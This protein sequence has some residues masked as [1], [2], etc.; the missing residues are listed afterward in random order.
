MYNA[1]STQREE[2][3]CNAVAGELLVPKDALMIV[4]KNGR[5]NKPYT[6]NEIQTFA[7]KFSVSKEVIIRRLLDCGIINDTEYKTYSDE[8][9]R[10]IENEREEQKLAR[11]AGL[12]TGFR[13]N[14]S[15]DAVDRTSSIV[16]KM[17]YYGYGEGTYSKRDI[18]QHLE[19]AQRH[20]DK[21]L[22]EVSRWNS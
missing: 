4:L 17:L 10:I 21:F 8:F 6:T 9:L 19:I 2:V 20:V 1:T 16:C 18:A 7:D 13:R 11:E 14:V 3:F 15:R 22:M 5:Y 12:Q